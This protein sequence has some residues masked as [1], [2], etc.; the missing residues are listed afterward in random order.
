MSSSG[1][2]IH[3]ATECI[4]ESFRLDDLK[5]RFGGDEFIVIIK[6]V[7]GPTAQV[8]VERYRQNLAVKC[9]PHGG[10]YAITNSIGVSLFP[11]HGKTVDELFKKADYALYQ[12]K[13][14]GKNQTAFFTEDA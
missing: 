2:M 5:G 4:K 11:Q 8:L 10:R 12:A 1:R 6:N 7:D 3:L 13:R 9:Q 14:Q